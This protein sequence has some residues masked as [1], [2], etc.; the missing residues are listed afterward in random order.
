MELMGAKV[1]WKPYSVTVTGPKAFGGKLKGID[2]NM[3]APFCASRLS[4]MPLP[5]FV[6][7]C[8]ADAR[9]MRG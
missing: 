3:C 1:E 7:G 6:S 2:V 4:R 5:L 8:K 9:L